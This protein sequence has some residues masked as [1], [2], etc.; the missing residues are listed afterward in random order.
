MPSHKAHRLSKKILLYI[1]RRTGVETNVDQRI[2]T[3]ARIDEAVAP[4]VEAA[5]A[6]ASWRG[7]RD[8]DANETFEKIAAM[9][10]RDTGFLRP[11]KSVSP[12]DPNACRDEERH[13]TWNSWVRR[14][15]EEL[16]EQVLTA[17]AGWREAVNK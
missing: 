6:M 2:N 12:L 9:F 17:L 1:E 4:L 15:N 5:E 10:L 14:K 7:M 8:S 13:N 16:D 3:A 11:G